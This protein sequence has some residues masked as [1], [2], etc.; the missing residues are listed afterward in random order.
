MVNIFQK[1][2]N[3]KIIFLVILFLVIPFYGFSKNEIKKTIV[4]V[5]SY[6]EKNHWSIRCKKAMMKKF[7]EE[8]YFIKLNE[9][10]LDEKKIPDINTRTNNVKKYFSQ[11]REKIDA[12]IVFDYGAT[13][14]FLTYTDSII[15][16]IP[17]IFVSELEPGRVV[18]IKNVT[19]IISDYGIGQVYKTGL[20]IFPNIKK[21][22]VWAD[23]SP[24]GT[25]FMKNAKNILKGYNN[26]GVEIEYGVNANSKEELL[27]KCKKLDRNSFIIFSTWQIDDKGKPYLATDLYPQI[28]K[29]TKVPI[30]TVFDGFIGSGFIGGFVQSAQHNGEA[31]AIKAIR[32]F[33][34][35]IPEKMTNDNIPPIPMFDY[36]EIIKKGG[37]PRVL[38]A[39][40][41][42]VNIFK[43]FFISHK[44][45]IILFLLMIVVIVGIIFQRTNNKKLNKRII[46]KEKHEKELE[47]NIKLLSFAVP[48][49]KTISCVYDE[50]ENNFQLIIPDDFGEKHSYLYSDFDFCFNFIEPIYVEKFKD[51]FKSL[52][53]VDEHYEYH[54]EFKGKFSET[55]P[56]SWWEVRGIVEVLEDKG[57]KYRIINGIIFNIEKFKENE[58]R[59]NEA[60]EKSIQSEKLK[61]NFIANISHEIR[62]PL[63]AIIG[64]TNLI[65]DSKDRE[66]QLEYKKI[67]RENNDILLNLVN[68]IIVLSEIEAGYLE[69][70]R[71]KFDLKQYFEEL[72]SIFKHKLKEGVELIIESP[73][74]SCIVNF[75]KVRLTQ[76]VKEFIDNAIKFTNEGYIKLGYEIVGDRIKFYVEDTGKG[77]RKEDLTKVYNRF[78]KL[79]SFEHGTGLGL[80][81][82]KA[83]LDSIGAEYGIESEEG[84]GTLCWTKLYTD[85]IIVDDN[86]IKDT[87]VEVDYN[88]NQKIKI[89]IADELACSLLLLDALLRER[90]NIICVKTGIEAVEKTISEKPDILLIS[91]ILQDIDGY[92]V[93]R[94]IRKINQDISIVAI[95]SKIL[96]HEKEEAFNAGCNEFVEKP[97]EK[98]VLFKIIENIALNKHIM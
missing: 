79:D 8:G 83:I 24:T 16:K 33:N 21:V 1:L 92:E 66:E 87:N 95:S 29:N 27:Q 59:L 86:N 62:T 57:G 37:M 22:Y 53:N 32:I 11:F 73:H 49:L 61:A 34:G 4:Y 6:T 51:F 93:I 35:E 98:D 45:L 44:L 80:A 81:I 67:V 47:L 19:G 25:F 40:T 63:N 18:N 36:A 54:F 78:E 9:L 17:I 55:E 39:N 84:K 48:S 38:P 43:A 75:D 94:R 41:V 77:I 72:E 50:R 42:S 65:I 88:N 91:L 76:V 96:P 70:K 56:Y 10:Y 90:Y 14:V 68:D 97:V 5:S 20:K 89:L 15:S 7:K 31:A 12:I 58:L 52:L 30:L 69:M 46:E 13:N 71:I 23:K 64:F 82:S 85:V 26:D 28:I 74:K 2:S 60:L 3:F